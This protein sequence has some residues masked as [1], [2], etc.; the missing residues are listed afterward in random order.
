MLIKINVAIV[1]IVINYS[2]PLLSYIS[3]CI[4][5]LIMLNIIY[6]YLLLFIITLL[7]LSLLSC[8]FYRL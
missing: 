2:V 7:P 5:K 6:Y 8:L 1:I 3:V 4:S